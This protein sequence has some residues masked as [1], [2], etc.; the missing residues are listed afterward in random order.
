MLRPAASASGPEAPL[1][2]FER[3]ARDGAMVSDRSG[4]DG[5][6]HS[7]SVVPSTGGTVNPTPLSR[8]PMSPGADVGELRRRARTTLNGHMEARKGILARGRS[9]YVVIGGLREAT[10]EKSS[11]ADSV[12]RLCNPAGRFRIH[13]GAV[14]R[15]ASNTG[16]PLQAAVAL[17]SNSPGRPAPMREKR[18]NSSAPL[19]G[20]Y[21]IV[22]A[23]REASRKTSVSDESLPNR[24]AAAAIAA[25]G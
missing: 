19:H 20:S 12:G 2:P 8:R 13:R 3:R 18:R 16:V 24:S 9:A 11:G 6:F 5:G 7:V 14:N 10:S 15:Y 23:R 17:R 25:L 22:I 4:N 21:A 1:A